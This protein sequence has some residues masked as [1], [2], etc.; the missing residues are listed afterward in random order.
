MINCILYLIFAVVLFILVDI[1]DKK[2]SFT[3]SQ[4]IIFKLI[5]LIILA[6]IFSYLGIGKA[7]K[8]IFMIIVIEFIFRMI[9]S[10]YLLGE[11]FFRK[12]DKNI[13][14]FFITLFSS[15]IINQYFINEL[16][17]V[18]LT[19]SELKIIIWLIIIICIYKFMSKD[20]KSVIVN[21]FQNKTIG[22]KAIVVN[23]AKLKLEYGDD[24]SLN[25]KNLL[26]ILYSIMIYENYSRP[27][28]LRKFDNLLFKI[29]GGKRKLGIMQVTSKKYISDLDSIEV[30]SK[31][32]DKLFSK[33]KNDDNCYEKV[34]EAYNKDKFLE[35][36]NIYKELEKFINL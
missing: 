18:F 25:D 12:E 29:N 30:V 19:A 14:K 20:E 4:K 10:L 26:T 32:L 22:A 24:I 17:T 11:D 28:F 34:L 33:Y 27:K 15:I 21:S 7:N 3:N 2:Y 13:Y 23:Y 6:G 8:N 36:N 35:I 5:Y 1:F 31:R 9:Y 16:D